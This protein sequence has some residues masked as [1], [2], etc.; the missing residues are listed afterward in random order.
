MTGYATPPGGLPPQ[1]EV[2]TDRAILTDAYAVIPR[3]V[4]RDIVTSAFPGWEGAR[5]WVLARPLSG[6]AE[7]F[8]QAIVELAPGGGSDAPEPDPGAEGALFVTSGALALT[9]AGAA[10]DLGP[11]GFAWLPPGAAW[12]VRNAGDAPCTVTGSARRGRGRRG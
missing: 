7:T 5:A 11:G 10:H 6:F 2:M 8:F 4:M 12:T 3:G 1:T 9:V